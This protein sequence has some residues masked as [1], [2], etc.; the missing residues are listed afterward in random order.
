MEGEAADLDDAEDSS[1]VDE[2]QSVERPD[3]TTR[4]RGPRLREVVLAAADLDR[5]TLGRDP[6]GE[7]VDVDRRGRLRGNLRALAASI[8]SR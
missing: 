2:G 8:R 1:V 7:V 3:A 5:R 6:A 4:E